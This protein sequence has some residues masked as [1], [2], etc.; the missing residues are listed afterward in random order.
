MNT[1]GSILKSMVIYLYL[2]TYFSSLFYIT[3]TQLPNQVKLNYMLVF[4]TS[5][6]VFILKDTL[7]YLD[8][9]D[10]CKKHQICHQKFTT[11]INNC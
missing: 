2:L 5:A 4:S 1:L 3:L 7:P 6:I 8:V 9:D 10:L 11:S